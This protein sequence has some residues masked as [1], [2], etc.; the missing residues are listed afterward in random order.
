MI[1]ALPFRKSNQQLD[2]LVDDKQEQSSHSIEIGWR[3]NKIL[4][5]SNLE[6]K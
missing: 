5:L 3:K 2:A 4:L 6:T 1:C